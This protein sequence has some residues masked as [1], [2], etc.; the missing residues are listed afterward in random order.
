ME[1]AEKAELVASLNAVFQTTGSV[2][3]C[4]NLGLT[5][6][7]VNDQRGQIAKAGATVKVAKNPQA[8]HYH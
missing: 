1:R 2:V 3:V 7:Q 4:H 6:A 8:K 5:V